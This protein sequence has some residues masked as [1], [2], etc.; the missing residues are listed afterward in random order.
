M[1]SVFIYLRALTCNG[2]PVHSLPLYNSCNHLIVEV[3]LRVLQ[4][5]IIFIII[6]SV[7]TR[8]DYLIEDTPCG[9]LGSVQS[10]ILFSFEMSVYPKILL[11]VKGPY[12]TFRDF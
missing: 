5:Y 6:V 2:L 1:L 12:G 7:V 3:A 9:V 11:E 4:Y 8:Q 10:D